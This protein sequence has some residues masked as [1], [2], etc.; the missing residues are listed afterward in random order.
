MGF[1]KGFW[2]GVATSSYQIEGA[3]REGGRGET[4]WDRFSHTPG[5]VHGGHTGDVACDHYHRYV[6][7]IRLLQSL[8]VNAYRFSVAWGRI[9]P[10]GKGQ[11]NLTGLDFYER[12][13]DELL[14][15]DIR[16]F[17]TLYHWDLPQALQ[18]LGGWANRDSIGWFTEYADV[19]SRRLGDRIGWYATFNELEVIAYRGH[20]QGRHAPGIQ[21]PKIAYQ[22]AHHL[23]LAH[24][25]AVPLLRNNAPEAQIGV[26]V[27][28]NYVEPADE[29]H[30]EE[31]IL[32]D[33]IKN[34]WFMDPILLGK[35]PAEAVEHLGDTL[36]GIET[37]EIAAAA[38]PLDFLGLNYYSRTMVGQHPSQ[39]LPVTQ[40]GWEIY[41]DGLVYLLQ[42]L[43]DYNAPP[44]YITENGAAFA[45]APPQNGIVE[46]A[47]RVDYFEGHLDALSRA[48]DSGV[49]VRG[50]FAWSLL[51]NFEWSFGYSRRFGLVYVDFATQQRTLKRSAHFYRDFIAQADTK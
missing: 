17:L 3:V 26:V 31:A 39:R 21:N 48:I 10:Q 7:D 35:Y 25:E 15:A 1:P 13:V 34:R 24:A 14:A 27:N 20:L 6:E 12:V 45:D 41:P 49:D 2:W 37:E 32:E 40:M 11:I 19:V 29:S 47:A 46:D 43:K 8:G 9:M 18:D 44:I 16:P 5:K 38:V 51:D 50:Y 23:M 36:Q 30:E 4:I 33:A 28:Q 42:R 22:V